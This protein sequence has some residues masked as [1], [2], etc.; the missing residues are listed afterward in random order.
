M[1]TAKQEEQQSET[2]PLQPRVT[3]FAH[4]RDVDM[5]GSCNQGD[6]VVVSFHRDV[7]VNTTTV[8]CFDL[9]VSGDSFGKEGAAIMEG[10]APNQVTILLGKHAY[11]KTRQDFSTDNR[12]K[13]PSG[14]QLSLT[15]PEDGIEN[16]DDGK[17][18]V[19]SEA[20]DII[21]D[22]VES[23]ITLA[24]TSTLDLVLGDLDQDGDLDIV[25][26]NLAEPTRVWI[27]EFRTQGTFI[28]SGQ[29][30][31]SGNTFSVALG[32]VD[33]DGDL[34]LVCGNVGAPNRLWLY[35]KATGE[36]FDSGQFPGVGDAVSVELAD[37][38]HDGSPDLI[39]GNLGQPN[40]IWFNDGAGTLIYSGQTWGSN[41]TMSIAVG[42]VN[43]D[44]NLD[45]IEGIHEKSNRLWLND[46]NNKGTF[47]DSGAIPGKSS[48]TSLALVDVDGDGDLDLAEGNHEKPNRIMLN[49]GEGNF[50][51]SGQKLGDGKTVSLIFKDM[52]GD[53]DVDLVSGNLE[54]PNR[55]WQNDGTGK[56]VDSGQVLGVNKTTRMAFGDLDC[57]GD[58]DIV[59]GTLGQENKLWMGSVSGTWGKVSFKSMKQ[60]PSS[61][62][63]QTVALGDVDRDGDLE[64]VEANYFDYWTGKGQPNY[65]WIN[66]GTGLFLDSGQALGSYRTRAIALGDLDGDGDLDV[67]EAVEGGEN[68]IYL[69]TNGIF[70]NAMAFGAAFSLTITVILGD[71]DRDG[72]LYMVEIEYFGNCHVRLN[73]GN[74]K[75]PK[76][77]AF[78]FNLPLTNAVL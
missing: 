5:N 52:D 30:L 14:I 68:W 27:N 76:R 66:D 7:I 19:W 12:V 65:I 51:F 3:G 46:K 62:N 60:A 67:A 54:E 28:D 23:T 9:P 72:D 22:F 55:V 31:G 64:I 74:G 78:G 41:N 58:L 71:L 50:K 26:A 33:R 20:I 37:V 70:D 13:A 75:F 11:L 73:N 42:D 53:S 57:D 18:A 69:N 24:G 39:A 35:D 77:H 59:E 1:V 29:V 45:I 43:R 25:E 48:T 6:T 56:F 36:Y 2:D 8:K 10:P 63:T 47:I 21:P 44:G 49:D 32:D 16:P 61:N 17:D 38:N 4:Y 15:M 40:E 34:D